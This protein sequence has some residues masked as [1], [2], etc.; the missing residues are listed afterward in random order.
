MV[1]N[2]TGL[3]FFDPNP[4]SRAYA[5][6]RPG[7]PGFG[8][9]WQEACRLG[10]LCLLFTKQGACYSA[11]PKAPCFFVTLQTGSRG[12]AARFCFASLLLCNQGL[13]GT[14]K[15]DRGRVTRYET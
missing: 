12:S 10:C 11:H 7:G 3:F 14:G 13:T 9:R 15:H 4:S 1:A 8:T 5:G 2:P 6:E